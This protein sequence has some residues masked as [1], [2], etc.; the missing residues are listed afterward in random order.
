MRKNLASNRKYERPA[1][2]KKLVRQNLLK[3]RFV[4]TKYLLGDKFTGINKLIKSREDALFS[5]INALVEL[6]R[7]L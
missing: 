4:I 1:S 2:E 3:L 7:H 6:G 5:N